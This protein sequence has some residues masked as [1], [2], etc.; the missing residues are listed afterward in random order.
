MKRWVDD[1]RGGCFC[2][3]DAKGG[4][5][6]VLDGMVWDKE[7]VRYKVTFNLGLG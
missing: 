5:H 3:R 6:R 7:A 4:T 1:G 2:V